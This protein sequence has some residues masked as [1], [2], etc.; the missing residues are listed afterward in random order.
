MKSNT[1]NRNNNKIRNENTERED[2][3]CLIMAPQTKAERKRRNALQMQKK[4]TELFVEEKKKANARHA[5]NMKT[6]REAMTKEKKDKAR[7][8]TQME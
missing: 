2:N 5:A 8:K 4:R 3:S 1:F 7:K 6:H